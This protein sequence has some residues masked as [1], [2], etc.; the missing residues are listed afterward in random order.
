MTQI[1]TDVRDFLV[2]VFL[3]VSIREICGQKLAMSNKRL[4]RPSAF[5]GLGEFKL[6]S[7][8]F[9]LPGDMQ[10]LLSHQKDSLKRFPPG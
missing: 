5:E 9:D 8:A 6:L 4:L 1:C 7:H 2:F 3:S 10:L